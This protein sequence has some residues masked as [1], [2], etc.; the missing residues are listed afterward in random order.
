MNPLG[1]YKIAF[2]QTP[3][4]LAV[5][6]IGGFLYAF[7][8]FML[9]MGSEIGTPDIEGGK[10]ILQNHGQ[11]IKTITEQEYHHFK[12][13]EMRGFSGHWIAFYGIAMAILYPFSRPQIA[14]NQN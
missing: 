9:F 14:V 11:L 2:K 12:A 8:N 13:N 4:W 7:L 10:Y 5:L 3:T 1:F 6:A